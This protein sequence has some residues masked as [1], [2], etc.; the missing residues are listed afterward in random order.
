MSGFW[1]ISIGKCEPQEKSDNVR[2]SGELVP[3]ISRDQFDGEA[4]KFLIRYCPEALDKPLKNHIEM[5][6]FQYHHLHNRRWSC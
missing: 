6:D 3:I 1:I 5:T 4:E 2:L